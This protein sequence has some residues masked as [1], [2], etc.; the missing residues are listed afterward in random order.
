MAQPNVDKSVTKLALLLK[1]LL[2]SL[3]GLFVSGAGMVA[4]GQP[5]KSHELSS[6]GSTLWH[7]LLA[8]HLVLL[9]LVT[10]SS[11]AAL[12]LALTKL[13]YLKIRFVV[14]ILAVIFGIVSGILV[15]H[16]IHP[17]IFL[18]CM[19]SAFLLIGAIYGPIAG[20][21]GRKK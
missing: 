5:T 13:E 7:I 16:K 3:I 21:G 1:I 19:A 14:G 11:I 20:H 2:G 10:F 15:L 12:F 9:I 18:F 17:G 4:I 6:G 8:V